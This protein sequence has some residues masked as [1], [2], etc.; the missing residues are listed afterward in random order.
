MQEHGIARFQAKASEAGKPVNW[1]DMGKERHGQ[2]T[3]SKWSCGCQNVRVGT[4]EFCAQCLKCG[5][6]FAKIDAEVHQVVACQTSQTG[7]V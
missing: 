4:R 2:F 5:N 1:R 3:L 7:G 6:V